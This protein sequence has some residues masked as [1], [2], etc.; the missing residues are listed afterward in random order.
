MENNEEWQDEIIE[1]DAQIALHSVSDKYVEPLF[2]LIQR[3]KNWLQKAMNWPQFVTTTED[4]RKTVQSNLMLHHRGY[5]KMF[6]ILY[7]DELVGVFSFNQIVPTDKTAYIG[8]WLSE[9][10]QGKG[11]VSAALEAVIGKYSAQG[12][13][14]RFV[15]KCIVTN[16]ASN[17]VAKRNGFTLEGCLRQAEYLNGEFHDQNIYGRIVD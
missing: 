6:M 16:I 15:I 8:Y 2:A 3:N 5:A 4:T 14:R 17:S 9:D 13:V 12:T 7:R 10:M 11:I 1:V